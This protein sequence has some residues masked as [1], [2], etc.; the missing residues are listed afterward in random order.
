MLY[1]TKLQ[2]KVSLAHLVG[3]VYDISINSCMELIYRVHQ[4]KVYRWKILAKLTNKRVKLAKTFIKPN[5][6]N[7]LFYI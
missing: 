7:T 6:F 4:K 3:S 5:K 2:K 1:L